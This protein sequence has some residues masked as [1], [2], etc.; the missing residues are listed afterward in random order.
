[1]AKETWGKVVQVIG[2]VIDVEFDADGLPEIYDA[3]EI[4]EKATE[5]LHIRLTAE[6]AQHL[7]RNQVRAVSMASRYCRSSTMMC[8]TSHWFRRN[9]G[10]KF[11]D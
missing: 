6:V 11:P 9:G 2:P 4:D 7:G 10:G 5:D 8:W 1:M 3:I